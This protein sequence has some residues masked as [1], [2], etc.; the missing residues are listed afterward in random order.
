M[1][2]LTIVR[3]LLSVS[4][5]M[6]TVLI[7]SLTGTSLAPA[8]LAQAGDT[9]FVTYPNWKR[10]DRVAPKVN[11][12]LQYDAPSVQWVYSYSL[13]NETSATQ[14]IRLLGL[15]FPATAS[16]ASAPSGWQAIALDDSSAIP[17][18][19][20]FA[21]GSAY[22]LG[23]TGRVAAPS[24]AQ[25]GPGSEVTLTLR[26][27]YPPGE[28]R[29][30]ARGYAQVPILP[31][32]VDDEFE[33]PDDTTDAQRGWTAGPTRYT[34][35][36]T[37]GTLEQTDLARTDRF[38]GF[39]NVDTSGSTFR[40]GNAI[41]VIK[42]DNGSDGDLVC[43]YTFRAF[44]NDV[45]VTNSFVQATNPHAAGYVS[46]RESC[47]AG[48]LRAALFT[49]KPGSPLLIGNNMF[50]A[51]VAGLPSTFSVAEVPSLIDTDRIQFTVVP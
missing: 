25:L 18:A 14:D 8:L 42:F 12:T 32:S 40:G 21:D 2:A 3:P 15:L 34:T 22:Q 44:L 35:V 37:F 46:T 33:V 19:S 26:S 38:L 24:A 51:T 16:V 23:V 49:V 17:G 5:L 45:D 50:R 20:F 31:D 6:Q 47:T 39:M 27:D 9:S 48:P 28:S 30:Y 43:P 1:P 10:A 13:R 11:L 29:F 36:R 41:I 7:V 4:R